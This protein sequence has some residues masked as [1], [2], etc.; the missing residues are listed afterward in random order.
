[1][2]RSQAQGG[3]RCPGHTTTTMSFPA[4][5]TPSARTDS[6]SPAASTGPPSG[7][8]TGLGTDRR[9]GVIRRWDQIPGDQPTTDAEQRAY[10]TARI[11]ELDAA[12]GL[13]APGSGGAA[14]VSA[15]SELGR[16]E[17]RAARDPDGSKGYTDGTI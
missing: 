4:V 14:W 17:S 8:S 12:G 3:R 11:A 5:A 10:L 15:R 13:L 6:P 2:C 7:P 9:G 16:L 1:M